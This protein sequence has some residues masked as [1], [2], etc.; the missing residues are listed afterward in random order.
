MSELKPGFTLYRLL[1]TTAMALCLTLALPS[2][3]GSDFP[4]N[5]A[6]ADDDG[7]EGGEG[8]EGGDDGGEGGDD[9]GEGGEGGDD[10][11]GDDG[12]EGG[13][14]EGGDGDD[15]GEGGDDG[16]EGDDDGGESAGLDNEGLDDDEAEKLEPNAGEALAAGIENAFS[17]A[18]DGLISLFSDD[19]ANVGAALAEAA[20]D[21][22]SVDSEGDV[23]D[24]D[25]RVGAEGRDDEDSEFGREVASTEGSD[26]DG[27]QAFE[28][29]APEEAST[30]SEETPAE[31]GDATA[32][33]A[34]TGGTSATVRIIVAPDEDSKA[35]AIEGSPGPAEAV[36]KEAVAT[37]A[38]K[39][40]QVVAAGLATTKVEAKIESTAEEV[41]AA[42]AA[43]EPSKP[44]P[45]VLESKASEAAA[46]TPTARD[47]ASVTPETAEPSVESK[48]A[49]KEEE[50][51]SKTV[52]EDPDTEASDAAEAGPE[53]VD[54]AKSAQL[55]AETSD[56]AAGEAE[57]AD[58]KPQTVEPESDTEAAAVED[59]PKKSDDA[60]ET[61]AEDPADAEEPS[62][63]ATAE[64]QPEAEDPETGASETARVE[65]DSEES[66][67]AGSVQE[68]AAPVG[69]ED[70][71]DT[72]TVEAVAAATDET[73]DEAAEPAAAEPEAPGEETL[74]ETTVEP[75]EGSETDGNLDAAAEERSFA[76]QVQAAISRTIDR[77]MAYF[78]SPEEER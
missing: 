28:A 58:S 68:A 53:A 39:P 24:E 41:E 59:D 8:G 7:G 36:A 18:F 33:Q 4:G 5:L 63:T 40:D 56:E 64:A 61:Q 52:A 34:L 38:Q 54:D 60:K 66:G 67:R 62:K 50:A 30:E 44:E 13:G 49:L 51:E 70:T 77:V 3:P 78:S 45:E 57:A 26:S 22:P 31:G 14:G 15:G 20:E 10:G 17:E 29:E 11:G 12:G 43:V 32:E 71:S 27:F 25:L 76:A 19:D 35:T 16:G 65:S 75:A 6:L 47:D 74:A 48:I 1:S 9:G 69:V 42:E 73:T 46:A 55:A 23:A 2:G 21:G 37:P 72:K